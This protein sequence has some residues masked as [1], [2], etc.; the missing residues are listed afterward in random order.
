MYNSEPLIKVR[1]SDRVGFRLLFAGVVKLADTPDLGSGAFGMGVQVPPPA[2][3]F[4]TLFLPF[5]LCILASCPLGGC[6]A[7]SVL[8]PERAYLNEMLLVRGTEEGN[9]LV[10][11]SPGGLLVVKKTPGNLLPSIFVRTSKG[12]LLK[13]D[14]SQFSSLCDAADIDLIRFGPADSVG[15]S[16]RCAFFSG[17]AVFKD[18]PFSPELFEIPRLRDFAFGINADTLY[19]T[20]ENVDHSMALGRYSDNSSV[21][22]EQSTPGEAIKITRTQTLL[23]TSRTTTIQNGWRT[24]S[25]SDGH[26][27][28]TLTT[29]IAVGENDGAPIFLV[30]STARDRANRFNLL[31]SKGEMPLALPK[32]FFPS[33]LLVSESSVW[34]GGRSG[35]LPAIINCDLIGQ[36]CRVIEQA[37]FGELT[38]LPSPDFKSVWVANSSPQ[39][40][41]ALLRGSSDR[42]LEAVYSRQP[43]A[44]FD[45]RRLQSLKDKAG[46][47]LDILLVLPPKQR[48]KAVIVKSYGNYGKSNDPYFNAQLM[49]FLREDIAFAF[50]FVRGGGECGEEWHLA[51]LKDQRKHTSADLSRAISTLQ[52]TA[53]FGEVPI[54][55]WTRSLG[56][57]AVME[58][59][60]QRQKELRGIILE[61]PHISSKN[62]S[63][64]IYDPEAENITPNFRL[65]IPTFVWLG[66][67][68]S[69]VNNQETLKWLSDNSRKVELFEDE[70]ASH[71]GPSSIQSADHFM[72]RVF[73]F[74]LHNLTD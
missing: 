73:R 72:A 39:H 47:S 35:C 40:G 15:V 33:R 67:N 41:D 12:D 16:V 66:K 69:T 58:V 21:V 48:P 27:T 29:A 70:L 25:L 37:T 61:A 32:D 20:S 28:G 23:F 34:L 38:L 64:T 59:T 46:V 3:S 63:S 56:A 4:F 31:S 13:G 42:R 26:E 54:F 55:L 8:N 51:G 30:D 65:E 60:S 14:L 74:V 53:E 44:N 49:P 62:D 18:D 17:V 68:D 43:N 11:P 71:S 50:P 1:S 19:A 6:S 9:E 10:L 2:F 5:F 7:P 57:Q 22:L 52:T 24:R 45:Q 36:G